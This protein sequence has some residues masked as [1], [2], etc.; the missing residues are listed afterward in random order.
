[1][2][3]VRILAN[4]GI[5]PAGKEMLEN[6]GYEVVTDTVMQEDLPVQLPDFDVILVRSATKVRKKLIDACPNLKIVGRGGVG[7]DN[8]DVDYAKDKDIAVFNTPAASSQSVAELVFAHAIGAARFLHQSN[9]NMPARGNSEFKALKKAYSAGVELRGKTIGIIGFGRIGQAVGRIAVGL[10][11][12]VL[13]HDPY[14]EQA[15]LRLDFQGSSDHIQVLVKTI[16]MRSVLKESDI[17]TL[18]VPSQGRPVIGEKELKDM[19][20]EAILINASRGGII[21]EEALIAALDTG[22]I[23]AAGLDVFA[24]EP[25]PSEALLNHPKISLSPHIGAA[26]GQAQA[27]IGTELADKIIQFFGD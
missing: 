5:H 16:S 24:N 20:S 2:A 22:E 13:A 14:L 18:H 6:A 4:D 27:N 8:I 11:M 15:T 12:K 3:N 17:V 23:A 9:R 1:M 7:L 25:T 21:H 10:G 19:K 26:T